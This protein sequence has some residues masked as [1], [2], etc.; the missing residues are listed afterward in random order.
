MK[1]APIADVKARLSAYLIHTQNRG[2]NVV[3]VSEANQSRFP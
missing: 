1:I 3:I 2:R